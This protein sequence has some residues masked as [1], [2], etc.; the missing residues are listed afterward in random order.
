[1]AFSSTDLATLEE[2]ISSGALEVQYTD[3]KVKYRSLD[4]MIRIRDLMKRDLGQKDFSKRRKTA[5]VGKGL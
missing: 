3:K 1:M 2:A 4:E 5:V